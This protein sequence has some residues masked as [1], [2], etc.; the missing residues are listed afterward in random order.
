MG[1]REKG[2]EGE[3]ET[4]EVG[5]PGASLARRGGTQKMPENRMSRVLT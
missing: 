2:G 4:K 5:K 3:G 1:V